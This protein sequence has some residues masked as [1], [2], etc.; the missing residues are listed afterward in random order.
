M[1]RT[2]KCQSTLNRIR[3]NLRSLYPATSIKD[4]RFTAICV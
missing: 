2:V 3:N 4:N 1:V